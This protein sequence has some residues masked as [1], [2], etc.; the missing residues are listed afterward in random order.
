MKQIEKHSP[1]LS[2]VHKIFNVNTLKLSYSCNQKKI[3]TN[4]E[5]HYRI[6]SSM[7]EKSHNSHLF[8][9][10][11]KY[12]CSLKDNCL[13]TNVIYQVTVRFK[14]N[15]VIIYTG[16]TVHWKSKLLIQNIF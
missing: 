14:R 8:K 15:P 10:R 7:H 1:K 4:Y 9:C 11:T 6:K 2:K 16:I 3:A 12:K 13:Q 5:K